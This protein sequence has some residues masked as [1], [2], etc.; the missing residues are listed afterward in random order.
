MKY[1]IASILNLVEYEDKLKPL[2]N[3]RPVA[4]L[5]FACRYRLIDFP[6]SSLYNAQAVSAALFIS[7]SGHSLYD[8]IRSGSSWGLDSVAGGGVFTHSQVLL[9][10]E[11]NQDYKTGPYYYDDHY[12]YV[13]KAKADYVVIM[14]SS[15]LSNVQLDS[16]LNYHMDK[17]CDVTVVYKKVK[18]SELRDDTIYTSL[19]VNGN[20]E[21][22]V[23]GIDWVASQP[24]PESVLALNMRMMVINKKLFL[25]YLFTAREKTQDISVDNLIQYTL[26]FDNQVSG[27][28][29]TG[30]LKVIEDIKSYYE[31]NMDML[32]EDNFNSLFYKSDPVR[33]RSKNSGPTY[34]GEDA[35]VENSQFANDCEI[36]GS[37][38]NSLF[39]RKVQL[40]KGSHVEDSIIMQDAYIE[41]D[42]YL[43]HVILDKHV[44]V[45]RG[46]RLEGTAEEPIVVAKDSVVDAEGNI[47]EG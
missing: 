24:D 33:T 13:S 12:K 10:S 23:E 27:F 8:H 26:D 6:F 37:V 25:D 36:F 20:E 14:G 17:E 47:V 38:K 29:Y 43:K 1:K 22:L 21:E 41:E 5:P 9:K 40:A 2:T 16:V 42:V 46:A 30:Y 19:R 39:F 4:S 35:V 28:E 45:Q 7:G 32:N 31:A 34:Y 3:R 44:Y 18:R 15:I 11:A